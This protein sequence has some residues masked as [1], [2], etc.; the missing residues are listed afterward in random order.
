MTTATILYTMYTL[1][2]IK[3]KFYEIKKV[4]VQDSPFTTVCC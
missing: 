1:H 2:K 4:L 3:L